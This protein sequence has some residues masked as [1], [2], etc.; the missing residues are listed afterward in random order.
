MLE[1]TG[2]T[3]ANPRFVALTNDIFPEEGKHYITI[4][5]LVDYAGGDAAL[6]APEESTEVGWFGWDALPQPLFIPMQNLLAG[7]SYP[8]YA[9][10]IQ[11]IL[12]SGIKE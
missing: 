8:R 3:G 1:E 12:A 10:I 2:V 7:R 6:T 5:M 9:D 4:W 11:F